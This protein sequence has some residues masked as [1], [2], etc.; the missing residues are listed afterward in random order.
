MIRK[1]PDLTRGEQNRE[2]PGVLAL[3]GA[4]GGSAQLLAGPPRAGA[5]V[6]TIGDIRVRNRVEPIDPGTHRLAPPDSMPDAIGSHKIIE[7]LAAGFRRNQGGEARVIPEGQENR[8]GIGVEDE[9]VSS[10]IVLLVA[11]GLLVLADD[12][13]GVVIDMDTAN[14]ADWSGPASPVHRCSRLRI[15]LKHTFVHEPVE[16]GPGRRVNPGM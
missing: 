12:I 15:T 10:P 9:H 14:H 5:P 16:V 13:A 4:A 7:R 8:F 11:A 6:V 3:A 1:D 2:K